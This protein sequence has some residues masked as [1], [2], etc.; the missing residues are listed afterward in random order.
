MK[1]SEKI[2]VNLL[3]MVLINL[4][5]IKFTCQHHVSDYVCLVDICL[6][7]IFF[8]QLIEISFIAKLLIMVH[9]F[10]LKYEKQTLSYIHTKFEGVKKTIFYLQFVL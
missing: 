5:I 10:V 7:F 4:L 2:I 3:L 6:F 9:F 8:Y 1:T